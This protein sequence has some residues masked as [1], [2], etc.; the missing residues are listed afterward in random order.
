MLK[1]P[2]SSHTLRAA[3]LKKPAMERKCW[4]CIAGGFGKGALLRSLTSTSGDV[5]GVVLTI[6][7]ACAVLLM[8]IG[9]LSGALA[10]TN[11]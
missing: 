1:R 4:S 10:A 6:V 11:I 8:K 3:I 7:L 5:A 2:A 9:Q